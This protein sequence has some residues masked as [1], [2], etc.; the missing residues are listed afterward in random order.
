MTITKCNNCS[1]PID[2]SDKFCKNCGT[3]IQSVPNITVKT[4]KESYNVGVGNLPNA[5]IHIGDK[6]ETS[7]PSTKEL[8]YISKNVN[9]RI[10]NGWY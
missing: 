3:P 1:S 9:Q 5:N 7:K 6:Y 10:K 8:A 4:G 2:S